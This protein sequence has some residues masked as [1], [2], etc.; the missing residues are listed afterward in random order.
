MFRRKF[1]T[2]LSLLLVID[3]RTMCRNM[4]P[5]WNEKLARESIAYLKDY[6]NLVRVGQTQSAFLKK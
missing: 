2:Q 5:K 6:F 3:I 4:K 1:I